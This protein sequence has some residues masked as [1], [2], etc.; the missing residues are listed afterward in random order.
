MKSNIYKGILLL[1][2][3]EL[4]F[5]SATVFVKFASSGTNIPAIEVSFFRFFLGFFIAG[6][7]MLRTKVSFKPVK[8]KLVIWRAILNTLAVILFFLSIKYTTLT[9][10]N[11]LNMTS[12]VFIFL[13]TPFI[14]K[15]RI[16][17]IQ[18]FYLFLTMLGIYFII[19]PNFI[20]INIGDWLG[21]LSGVVSALA[22][23]T[24]RMA[25]NFDSTALILFYLMAIG[26]IINCF[27]LLPVFVIPSNKQ[28][29]FII[30]SAV[31]GFSGQVF[32]T[33]GYKYI[34]AAK[35]SLVSS[36]RIIY[37]IIFGVLIFSERITF[38][39]IT[40]SI[41]IIVSLVGANWPKKS[42]NLPR[43]FK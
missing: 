20:Q 5:A 1:A 9:N 24:L 41:L 30:V 13:F 37:A 26:A 23:M 12:P 3:S 43:Y 18:V 35:G 19:N 7:A 8:T 28:L 33:S 38:M 40:G 27:L 11:M 15:E 25:R 2:I 22:V 29:V 10:A 42:L 32:I 39:W 36:T 31:L 17:S 21:L 16:K 14:T 4:C 34:E 6:F